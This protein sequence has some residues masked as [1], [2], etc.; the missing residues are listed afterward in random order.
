MNTVKKTLV[1]AAVMLGFVSTA[2]AAS[3]KYI[4]NPY[5]GRQDATGD[6]IAT[7][8]MTSTGVLLCPFIDGETV[9]WAACEIPVPPSENRLLAE[10]NDYLTTEDD[11]FLLL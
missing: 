9:T 3:Q 8:V 1:I 7:A 6:G 2:Q 11:M 10:N 5:T 4:I